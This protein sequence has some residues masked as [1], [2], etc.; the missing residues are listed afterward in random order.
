MKNAKDGQ[1]L[2]SN[3]IKV[4]CIRSG[5]RSVPLYEEY[6]FD[7]EMSSLLVDINCEFNG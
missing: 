3:A 7:D 4:E 5:L 6:L 1:V 2:K